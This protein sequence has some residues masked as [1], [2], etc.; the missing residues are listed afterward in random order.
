MLLWSLLACTG[1][2]ADD[3]VADTDTPGDTDIP[4]DTAAD[5]DTADTASEGPSF[6]GTT[7]GTLDADV[8]YDC[9]GFSAFTLH[10]DG[11]VTGD[12]EAHCS[13]AEDASVFQHVAGPIV[14]AQADDALTATWT[15]TVCGVETTLPLTGTTSATVVEATVA[16]AAPCALAVAMSAD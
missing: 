3:T 9:I 16:T 7:R 2:P 11:T 12:A 5:T 1:A 6:R 4:G 8:H 10:E 14:G 15:A 13:L